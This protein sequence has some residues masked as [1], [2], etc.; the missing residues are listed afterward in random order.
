MKRLC[1][2]TIILL[3]YIECKA[4]SKP[5]LERVQTLNKPTVLIKDSLLSDSLQTFIS[6]LYSSITPYVENNDD[7]ISFRQISVCVK[8]SNSGNVDTVLISDN[9]D[10]KLREHVS[11]IQTKLNYTDLIKAVK[12]K[13]W[14]DTA[15]IFPFIF[16]YETNKSQSFGELMK[17]GDRN[18]KKAFSFTYSDLP[19]I[20]YIIIDPAISVF[21]RKYW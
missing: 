6:S 8:I 9:A 11:K 14:N 2:F 15:I 18:L 16:L 10:W 13:K 21:S 17:Y 19:I 12:L 3:L 4:Q 20:N 7:G 5:V 1:L